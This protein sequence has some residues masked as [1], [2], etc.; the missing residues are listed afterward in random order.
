VEDVARHLGMSWDTVKEIHR[1]VLRRKYAHPK[2]RYL[3]YLGV[4][5]V[6][7]RNGHS[8]LTIVVDLKTGAVVWVAKDR[9]TE[10][11]DSFLARV[12]RS[13]ATIEAIAIDMWP[14]YITTVMKHFSTNVIV[15]DRYHIIAACNSMLDGVRRGAVQDASRTEQ[16]VYEEVRYLLLWGEEKIR[17]N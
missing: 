15:F 9:T 3:K 10:S 7:V 16:D 2:L 4:D 1:G 17:I 5:E 11:L 6:A 13:G 12:K 14:A 8:Y